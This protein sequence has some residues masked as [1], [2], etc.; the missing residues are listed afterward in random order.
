MLSK[1]DPY[2]ALGLEQSQNI[3]KDQIKNQCVKVAEITNFF[4]PTLSRKKTYLLT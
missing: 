4:I 1:S 2:Y 3:W